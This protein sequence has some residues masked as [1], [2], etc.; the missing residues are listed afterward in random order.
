MK[1]I[2]LFAGVGGFRLGLERAGHT[3]VWANE[4]DKYAC[5]VYDYNYHQKGH[6]IDR[7]DLT[8]IPASDIPAH[9]LITGGF[10]CQ[11]FSIAG[12]RQGFDET[13]GTLFFDIMRIAEHHRTPYLLLENVKGLL[14]HDHGR[15]FEVILR[16]LD[17]C[18]YDAQ[19]QVLNSKNFGVPQNRERTIIVA[20]L[21]N[22]PRPEI[23]PIR[24]P[25]GAGIFGTIQASYYKGGHEGSYVIQE[26]PEVRSNQAEPIIKQ[27]NPTTYQ[28]GR[29]YD[30]DGIS[31]TINPAAAHGGPVI[32]KI[33]VGTV[34]VRSGGFRPT[35]Q[36]NTINSNYATGIVG[37]GQRPAVLIPEATS[38]GYAEAAEGDSVNLAHLESATR[39]GRVGKGIAQTL[40]A[41]AKQ[42]TV[43]AGKIRRLTPLEC[44]R[45]Q[46]FPDYW[47]ATGRKSDGTEY[48]VSDTQ[49]YK[50][51]GNAVTTNVIEAVA[52]Y[53]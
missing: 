22:Q 33:Q 43:T 23:F 39:R 38:K 14:N 36:A 44:E 3:V 8:T 35:D 13:R 30:P 24:Q 50:M 49:R 28:D 42:H 26:Q 1:A 2:E 41:A 21:R 47:T 31:P 11:A 15:T 53:L 17:E 9:D 12:K 46:A 6:L 20:N 51:M 29:V 27:I 5:D 32:P 4:W 37:N 10:P 7:R 48:P 16:T 34:D 40:D 25:S 45:L 19:W 18:G 52:S